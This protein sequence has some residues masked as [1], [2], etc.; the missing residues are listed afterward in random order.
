MAAAW[1]GLAT[2]AAWM[3]FTQPPIITLG[4][5]VTSVYLLCAGFVQQILYRETL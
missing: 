4:L 2:I 3:D 1:I 5:A